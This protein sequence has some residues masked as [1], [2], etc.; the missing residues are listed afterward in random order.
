VPREDEV[1]IAVKASGLCGSEL[2]AFHAPQ[3]QEFNS[4]HEV[5]G[6]IVEAPPASRWQV[7]DRV[8]VHAVWGCGECAYCQVGQY[9]YCD[10]RTSCPGSHAQLLAAP[11]HVCLQLPEDVP[12]DLGVLLTGDGLGV[13]YHVSRRLGTRGGEVVLVLGVG[14]IGLGNVLL[15][16]FLG[17]EVIAVD[18]NDYRLNLARELGAAHTLNA[19]DTDVLEAVREL[20]QGLMADKVVEATGKPEPLALA[21]QCVTKGGVVAAVG[22]NREVTLHIGRDLIRPDVTLLGSWFY[23]YAEYPA[24]VRLYRRGLAVDALITDHFP[25]RQAQAAFDKFAQGRTGKVILET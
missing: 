13:P 4:G 25:L 6:I 5:T 12:F 2:H 1:L 7:G 10:R 15:Q 21:L 8:G 3:E 17:A 20:T 18:L 23:H 14:P 22:E 9:T 24:M 11:E 16:S 19:G